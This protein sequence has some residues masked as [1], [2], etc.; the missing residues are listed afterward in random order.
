[1]VNGTVLN[2]GKRYKDNFRAIF[3]PWSKLY[4]GLDAYQKRIL[5]GVYYVY[6]LQGG[7]CKKSKM[8]VKT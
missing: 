1:M 6:L 7:A 3:D 4:L 5:K 8:F 2:F